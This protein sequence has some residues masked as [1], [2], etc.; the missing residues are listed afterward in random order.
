M[1]QAAQVKNPP[2]M[3]ETGVHPLGQEG[4]EYEAATRSSIL[5]WGFHGQR[6]LADYSPLGRKELDRTEHPG[7]QTHMLQLCRRRPCLQETC[8]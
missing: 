2:A 6:S 5:A 8:C 3:Q 7:S 4:L 1:Y